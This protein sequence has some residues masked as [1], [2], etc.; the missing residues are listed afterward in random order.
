MVIK[1]SRLVTL[2][3]IA[4]AATWLFRLRRAL[5]VVG[6]VAVAWFAI[7]FASPEA[8]SADA[9]LPL[10]L[11]LWVALALGVGH[12]L[13][14]APPAVAPDDGFGLRLRKRL[15]QAGYVVVVVAVVA[16]GAL[17]VFLTFRAI[18]L[19]GDVI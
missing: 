11:G 3:T 18:D 15:G 2:N 7:A 12:T 4:S 19:A 13:T 14:Q 8:T 1:R 10:S 9:L 17:A 5:F 16:L 6:L